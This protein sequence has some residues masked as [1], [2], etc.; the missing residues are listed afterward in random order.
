MLANNQGLEIKGNP[1]YLAPEILDGK[2]YS[3][4]AADV[5]ALGIM[6]FGLL[7]AHMPWEEAAPEDVNFSGFLKQPMDGTFKDIPETW[8]SLVR[9]MVNTDPNQRATIREVVA[10]Q[11]VVS[12]LKCR[13]PHIAKPKA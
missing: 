11:R 4:M 6:L 3:P 7:T 10:D 2:P 9:R 12:L 13:V 8:R 1:A 5:W